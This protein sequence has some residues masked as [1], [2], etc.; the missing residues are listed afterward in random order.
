MA[1]LCG[2]Y[3][4]GLGQVPTTICCESG[5]EF[6]GF[7]ICKQFINLLSIDFD[8]FKKY[9][10]LWSWELLNLFALI[11]KLISIINR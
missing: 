10:T 3:L 6:L 9:S 11:T 7:I 4:S 8:F 5:K 1:G 2:I